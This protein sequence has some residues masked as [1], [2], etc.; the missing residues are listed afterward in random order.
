MDVSSAAYELNIGG[1]STTN[2][3]Q[4]VSA[5]D[6]DGDER[7]RTL[8]KASPE[9]RARC[10][11]VSYDMGEIYPSLHIVLVQCGGRRLPRRPAP[12]L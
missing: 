11:D 4:E 6:E 3:K 12:P 1:L 2:M 5:N 10:A 8:D 7:E 9:S